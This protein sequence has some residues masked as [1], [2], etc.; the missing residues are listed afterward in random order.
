MN[1]WLLKIRPYTLLFI[2][3][4]C[5]SNMGCQSKKEWIGPMVAPGAHWVIDLKPNCTYAIGS[6]PDKEILDKKPYMTENGNFDDRLYMFETEHLLRINNTH[7]HQ[8]LG[9]D[10]T[11]DLDQKTISPHE[12]RWVYETVCGYGFGASFK[13]SRGPYFEI[14]W[15]GKVIT[16]SYYR[17]VGFPFPTKW[18]KISYEVFTGTIRYIN[19]RTGQELGHIEVKNVGLSKFP[20][21]FYTSHTTGRFVLYQCMADPEHPKLYVFREEK[22]AQLPPLK[23]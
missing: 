1:P 10:C 13:G 12:N 7:E 19:R 23:Y 17:F 5:A 11:Y 6:M 8:D 2:L 14:H 16:R 22:P 15:D 18:K 3:M 4:W 21:Q 20:F 9:V